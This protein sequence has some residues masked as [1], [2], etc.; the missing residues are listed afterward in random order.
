MPCYYDCKV[1]SLNAAAFCVSVTAEVYI[2]NTF[3]VNGLPENHETVIK[4]IQHDQLAQPK[5][6]LLPLLH[7]KLGLMKK[8]VKALEKGRCR[9]RL[10]E[11]SISQG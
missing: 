11:G 3:S 5:D 6:I 4:N 10:S 8:F 7:I 2:N 1:I 9:L